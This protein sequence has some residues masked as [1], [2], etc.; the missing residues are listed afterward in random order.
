MLTILAELTASYPEAGLH[1]VD[2]DHF[3]YAEKGLKAVD[4]SAYEDRW[5]LELYQDLEHFVE[6]RLVETKEEAVRVV[7]DW[8]N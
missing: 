4:V 7:R 8:L 2:G 1:G 6:E 3:V 5:L